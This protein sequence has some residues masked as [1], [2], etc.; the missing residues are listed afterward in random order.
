MPARQLEIED[1]WECA[2]KWEM[3]SHVFVEKLSYSVRH[4]WPDQH[5]QIDKW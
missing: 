4:G 3:V 2:Q 1:Q 5:L